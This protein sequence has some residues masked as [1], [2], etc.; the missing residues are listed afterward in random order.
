[1]PSLKP[2]IRK[3]RIKVD[4]KCRIFIRI[5]HNYL[6]SRKVSYISTPYN[7]EPRF[8]NPDGHINSKYPGQAKLNINLNLLLN[9]Y[10]GIIEGIGNDIRYMN[11][12]SLVSKL[13]NQHDNGSDIIKY[14]TNRVKTLESEKRYSTATI[15]N[16]T[17]DK[18][19][20][21]AGKEEILFK[22][23]NLDFLQRF[24]RSLLL[25]E[26]RINSI[27]VYLN[28]I[29]STFNHAI[30]SDTIKQELFPFR[31]FKIK[32]EITRKRN[33][34]PE[35]IKKLLSL[36]LTPIRR[37]ALDLFMLSF[38][39]LGM[40]FK[41]MLYLTHENVSEGRIYYNRAK[42][43]KSYSVMIWPEAQRI[44]DKYKGDKYLLKFLDKSAGT[45]PEISIT[46]STNV[47][48]KKICKQAEMDIPLST[49][50]A[51][52]SVATIAYSLGIMEST[53]SEML[54]HSYGNLMTSVYIER[55]YSKQDEANRK[56]IDAI[57][58]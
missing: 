34:K 53:I 30:D 20:D 43:K 58:Q 16:G 36:S 13:R 54:G 11:I 35:D 55:D 51:R 12:N 48:L 44:F 52:H 10:N 14:M 38:Y 25:E 57:K 56:V 6:G 26:K 37:Q 2:I 29:R 19:K 32:K 31:K 33:L 45:K 42:T 21:F 39:L 4:N 23:V 22:E 49:Y 27:R 24:E 41:D 28:T 17:I 3:Q 50:F 1:M 7:I 46:A 15:Y 47:Q 8:M 9:E 5:Y 40:N 18:L